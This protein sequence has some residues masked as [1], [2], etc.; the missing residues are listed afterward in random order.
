MGKWDFQAIEIL[1]GEKAIDAM[2]ILYQAQSEIDGL[3]INHEFRAYHTFRHNSKQY[4]H[5]GWNSSNCLAYCVIKHL[6]KSRA[7]ISSYSG[8]GFENHDYGDKMDAE[9]REI[10]FTD[11]D[12]DFD[13][14]IAFP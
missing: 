5:I 14:P 8:I 3:S 11:K 13:P 12:K 9:A 7:I 6:G 2:K 10:F 4:L 1:A